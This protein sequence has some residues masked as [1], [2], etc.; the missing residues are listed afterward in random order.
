MQINLIN[1]PTPELYNS[2]SYPSLGLLYLASI[3][4]N[5]GHKINYIQGGNTN[6]IDL[7]KKLPEADIDA[8]SMVT[9]TYKTVKNLFQEIGEKRD[10]YKIV[11]GVHP[12][13]FPNETLKNINVDCV[14]TGEAETV[15]E[16]V[17]DE[18]PRGIITAGIVEN[19]DSLPF[20]SRDLYKFTLD[21]SGI[22]G[23]PKPSTTVI[24]SRGC[25]FKCSFCCKT[26][27]MS[28]FRFR[29]ARD[30]YK[31][32]RQL[33]DVG[34]EHVRFIDDAFSVHKGRVFNLC[35]LIKKLDISYIAITRTDSVNPKV[36]KAMK[37]SGCTEICYGIESGSQYVLNLMNKHN[38]VEQ[39][40]LAIKMT[41]EA[42]IKVKVFLMEGFP[43]ER[44]YD[45]ELTKKFILETQPDKYTVSQ[46]ICLP[47]SDVWNF[48]EKYNHKFH[49]EKEEDMFNSWFYPE[50]DTHLKNWMEYGNWRKPK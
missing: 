25:P 14:V 27:A 26:P 35:R 32:L 22:H 45:R 38:T 10:T 33:N 7:V 2:D 16:R 23:S 18:Q 30:I 28:R 47:G 8:V 1:P 15:I 3:L 21:K 9:P 42:G 50:G 46:F 37:D 48:P 31:E 39:N 40:A 34:V 12:T 29:S 43:G 49:A 11:G 24:T 20:P 41:K 19:L 36:L 4:R 17:V 6:P 5:A 44:L 13:I